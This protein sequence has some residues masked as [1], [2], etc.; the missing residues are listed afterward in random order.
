MTA[1]RTLPTTALIRAA[2]TLRFAL[3]LQGAVWWCALSGGG[4]LAL[5]LLD[6]LL[7]LPQALRLPLAVVLIGFIVV[8]LYRK[9]LQPALRPMTPSRAARM[10]EL[11]RGIGGNVLINAFQFENDGLDAER[12]KYVGPVLASSKAILANIPPQTL[13]LTS[14]LKKWVLG[15]VVLI[16][17]WLILRS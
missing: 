15:L 17:A 2:K 4:L 14:S 5:V 10:L 7:H 13:W 9:V 1:N 12:G 11:N 3:I 6:N 16:A 8:Q